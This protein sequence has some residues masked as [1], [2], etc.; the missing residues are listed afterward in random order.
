MT[1]TLPTLAEETARLVDSAALRT[2]DHEREAVG[3]RLQEATAEK[4][5]ADDAAA[6]AQAKLDR[7]LNGEASLDLAQ[8]H[9]EA[10][11]AARA[12]RLAGLVV[13]EAQKALIDRDDVYRRARGIAF[14]PLFAAGIQRRLDAAQRADEARAMLSAAEAE[15]TLATRMLEAARSGGTFPLIQDFGSV[16]G[17]YDEELRRWTG[18]RSVHGNWWTGWKQLTGTKVPA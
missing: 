5:R 7:A 1:N 4:L 16:L 18:D 9:A 13:E 17:T 11:E 8:A 2:A 15:F 14:Q 3:Q 10:E 6:V 12:A